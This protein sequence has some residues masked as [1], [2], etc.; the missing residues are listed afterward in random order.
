MLRRAREGRWDGD[1][2]GVREFV[3]IVG[4]V[5]GGR[6]EREGGEGEVG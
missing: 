5:C 4:E 2:E 1:A 6:A 3:R